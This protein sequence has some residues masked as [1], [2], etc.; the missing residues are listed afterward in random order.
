MGH[1][2]SGGKIYWEARGYKLFPG[3]TELRYDENGNILNEITWEDPK[4]ATGDNYNVVLDD[5]RAFMLNSLF[6]LAG[7]GSISFMCFGASS[8]TAVHT[9]DRLV[10]EL[11]A[12]GTRARLLNSAGTTL[13]NASTTITT[14]NDTS[15][16]PTYSYYAQTVVLGQINGATSLNVNNPIQEV[17]MNNVAA[18]PST[19]TDISGTMFNRYVFGSPTIL[20]SS[21]LYQVIVTLHF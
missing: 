4:I 10:H 7:S 16:T 17:G 2:S 13:T 15:Y 5:G 9:Q 3:E 6:A 1:N 21:T 14:Y 20:D 12:D 18:C 8:T 11:I 19:P